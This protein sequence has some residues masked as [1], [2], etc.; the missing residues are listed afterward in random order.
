[1]KA[2]IRAFNKARIGGGGWRGGKGGGEC[3]ILRFNRVSTCV[4]EAHLLKL[5][6][7]CLWL[8]RIWLRLHRIWIRPHRIWF[9]LHRIWPRLHDI[10]LRN[11]FQINI[12]STGM[13]RRGWLLATPY[14]VSTKQLDLAPLLPRIVHTISYPWVSVCFPLRCRHPNSGPSY[15]SRRQQTHIRR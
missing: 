10:S 7:I 9:S 3:H 8:R 13:G 11:I 12:A 6:R 5:Y 2:I 14:R 15:A 4:E 1:M